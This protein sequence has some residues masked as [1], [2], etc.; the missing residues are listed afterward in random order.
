[1]TLKYLRICNLILVD[2]KTIRKYD[3]KYLVAKFA[4]AMILNYIFVILYIM[5]TFIVDMGNIR[6]CG[7]G[8]EILENSFEI[9]PNLW[10]LYSFMQFSPSPKIKDLNHDRNQRPGWTEKMIW[11]FNIS[12]KYLMTKF[13]PNPFWYLSFLYLLLLKNQFAQNQTEFGF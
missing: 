12:I 13:A 9:G 5:Y 2:I 8:I 3:M 10:F 1:M 4:P 11:N 7:S 6:K